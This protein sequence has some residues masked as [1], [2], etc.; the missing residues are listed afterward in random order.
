M[1]EKIELKKQLEKAGK[2]N[3]EENHVP[4][5]LRWKPWTKAREKMWL[6]LEKMWL[7]LDKM[8]EHLERRCG[9]GVRSCLGETMQRMWRILDSNM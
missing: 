5:K 2:R 7:N 1:R 4:L 8:H 3:F 6:N 9:N